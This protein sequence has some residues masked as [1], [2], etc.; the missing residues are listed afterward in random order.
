MRQ[1]KSYQRQAGWTFWSLALAIVFAFF[2]A[3]L[4]LQLTT[5]YAANGNVKN[6]MDVALQ[7]ADLG[8]VTRA[9]IERDM[10]NQL[11]LDGSHDVLDFK[12]DLIVS[13]TQKQLIIETNYKREVPLFLN[14]S[15][16]ARFNNKADRSLSSARN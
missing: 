4:G 8:R 6:A 3:Y 7:N 2:F 13:R 16:V 10:Q 11:S 15:L 14:L 5:I 1:I 9:Q 12:T